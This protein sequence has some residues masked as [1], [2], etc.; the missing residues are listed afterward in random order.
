[1]VVSERKSMIN[2]SFI[3]QREEER[4]MDVTGN[5][6]ERAC[7]PAWH[8]LEFCFFKSSPKKQFFF[9]F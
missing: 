2:V 3:D 8:I 1:M 6:G 9:F 7:K 4:A 5:K